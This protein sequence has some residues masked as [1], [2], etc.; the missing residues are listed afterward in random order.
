MLVGAAALF[1]LIRSRGETLIAPAAGAR[2]TTTSVAARAAPDVFWHL[3]VALLAVV[4]AGRL[5]SALFSRIGQPPV[6]GEVVGGILLGPSLLGR[7]APEAY[8]YILPPTVA[9]FLGIVAQLGVLFYMFLVGLELNPELLRG[10]IHATV[11]TSHASIVLPF[12]LGAALA[13]Y[14]YPRF[15][16]NNVPF[17]NFALFLGLAMSIT[18]FPVL[19]RILSDRG[20][21]RTELGAIALTCA[22]VDDVTAWCLLAFV[23]GVVQRGAENP[24]LVAALTLGFIGFMFAAVRPIA[25]RLAKRF[26]D[27]D[28][29][30]RGIA[31][32]LVSM[33]LAALTTEAI[34]IHAIFGAFLFG[35]V[36]PHESKLA[37]E[38]K[39][40]LE[41]LVTIL[42][43]PAFF[44]FTGMRTEI[45]LVSGIHE[46]LICGLIIV[47]ATTGKFGGAFLAAR[48]TGLDWRRAAGLGAL[49][50][51]RGLME[52]IVLNVGLELG[53]L[54]PTLFTMMVL[55]ALATTIATTPILQRLQH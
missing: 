24:L 47:V 30:Q 3:L 25:A 43:L 34:G 27:R 50:N 19:A 29:T 13:L 45:G 46:W 22:A 12:L 31:L 38:L 41:N 5:L 55:M 10:R 51:T 14:L 44:A 1:L 6:I 28:R 40:S 17:T 8:L 16:T 53:V 11:A 18:A 36:I 32:A 39:A 9:P 49:M 7:V 20:I 23:A 33:L 26:R 4:L 21:T 48:A 35:A 15:S 37:G 54:S 2:E 42:L 52:L